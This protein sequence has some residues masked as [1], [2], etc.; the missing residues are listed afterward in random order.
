MSCQSQLSSKWRSQDLNSGLFKPVILKHEKAS[1]H[2]GGLLKHRFLGPMQPI[3]SKSL[4]PGE[5]GV[6]V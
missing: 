6:G 3:P 4:I 1:S 5:S 2:L